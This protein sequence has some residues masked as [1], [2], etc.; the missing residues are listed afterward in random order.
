[1]RPVLAPEEPGKRLALDFILRNPRNHAALK[2]LRVNLNDNIAEMGKR[3][4]SGDVA[5][6]DEFMQIYCVA[7]P[8]RDALVSK[9]KAAPSAPTWPG[10][11]WWRE[12]E[13][14]AWTIVQVCFQIDGESV[15]TTPGRIETKLTLRVINATHETTDGEF[16][17]PIVPPQNMEDL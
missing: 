12:G 8:Q 2:G 6:V 9:M 13:N 4:Y 1:M 3:Y 11:Y 16:I 7:T 5:A 17:G 10:W 15:E 14:Y